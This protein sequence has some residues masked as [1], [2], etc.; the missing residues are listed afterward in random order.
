M[1][2]VSRKCCAVFALALSFTAP[3]FAHHVKKSQSGT[4]PVT[5]SSAKA[6]Q[7]YAKGMEDYENLY[8][9][10]C[11]EDWRAAVKED[12]DLAV[13]WAWIAFNSGNPEEV[14]A[15]RAKAKE[16]AP[17]AT[18]GEQLMVAWISKV[19]EGDFIGG[20][21]AMNDLLEMFPR[22]KHLLYLAGNWLMGENG[23]DQ[24]EHFMQKALAIDK[25]FPAALNDLAYVEARHREFDKAFAAMDR[26]LVL[27]PNEPNPQDSYGEL[28][29][30]AGQFDSALQHYQAA[31]KMDPD[32]VSSQLGLGD[33][34]ALMGNEEQARVE[35][36]KAI[37]FAHNEADRLTYAMQRAM[38]YVR[39]G[40]LAEADKQF[41]EIALNAHAKAQGLQEAQAY[42]HKAEYQADDNAA[43]RE[44][45]FAEEALHHQASISHS[46]RNEETS[47]IWRIRAVRAAHAG[48]QALAD[49]TLKDLE[50]LA[51]SSRNRVI[52]A[53]YQGAAGTLLMDQKKYEE[54]IAHLEEDEDN[55]FTME[56]LVQA[57]YQTSQ[58]EK[59]HE[60][61][62]KLRGT[63]V[64]TMEQALVVPAV[65]SRK[66]SL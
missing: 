23:D 50:A 33:T 57:Y 18:A 11:N 14:S 12:P 4:L 2:R 26:Y 3:L 24:A 34:Y 28:K 55:P 41:T 19:Q 52:Q 31:L 29:R 6:R 53:S 8:L 47:R 56:L 51:N 22:D 66:P 54:A 30:M 62:V 38:T 20:I 44:L 65:R 35:Y 7:L 45:K 13:A 61:E 46:D 27:L 64:P 10:R 5:S 63:N 43:L 17:K 16:L 37:R 36:D 58:P 49:Q 60:I 21:S 15:A 42:R 48:N 39:D 1:P 59:L 32:F 9:E 25:N 40:N